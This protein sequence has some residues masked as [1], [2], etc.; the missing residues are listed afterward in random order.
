MNIQFKPNSVGATQSVRFGDTSPLAEQLKKAVK[1]AGGPDVHVRYSPGVTRENNKSGYR[2]LD[3]IPPMLSMVVLPDAKDRVKF[4]QLVA[5]GEV[6]WFVGGG[7]FGPSMGGSGAAS[8]IAAWVEQGF[9]AQ[10]VDGV[11]L[12]DLSTGATS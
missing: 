2:S 11:T 4:Q 6:H 9:E 5:A 12:Y 8:E 7:G 10:T 1:D 3:N